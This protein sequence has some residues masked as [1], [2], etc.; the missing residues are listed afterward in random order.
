M[1]GGDKNYKEEGEAY[2]NMS[3]EKD[4]QEIKNV[5]ATTIVSEKNRESEQ[6]NGHE[7]QGTDT[8]NGFPD[9]RKNSLKVLKVTS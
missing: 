3:N 9:G 7:E 2:E 6:V 1:V 8:K 4:L 5:Q